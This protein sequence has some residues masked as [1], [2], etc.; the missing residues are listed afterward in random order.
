MP[1]PTRLDDR[2]A[3]SGGPA[4]TILCHCEPVRAW[5]S[6]GT[7]CEDERSTRRL[8]RRFAPRTDSGC[9]QFFVC[10]DSSVDEPGRWRHASALQKWCHTMPYSPT[11]V[12]LW[13]FYSSA[14]RSSAYCAPV[15]AVP[16]DLTSV[17][18]A[19]MAF[20]SFSAASV[21]QMWRRSMAAALMMEAGLA[22]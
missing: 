18:H 16:S 12:G 14:I 4:G 7:S 22:Y 9:R 3:E 10:F 20:S 11:F 13:Y 15:A 1:T 21:R 2:Y 5:Q 17:V 8:P 19:S 6:P